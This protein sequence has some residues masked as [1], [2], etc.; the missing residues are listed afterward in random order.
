MIRRRVPAAGYVV[1]FLCSHARLVVETDGGRHD[2]QKAANAD[3][4]AELGPVRCR[5]VRSCNDEGPGTMNGFGKARLT[6]ETL[7]ERLPPN[8]PPDGERTNER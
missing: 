8:P 1:D 6:I 7:I 3:G 5:V 2:Q 4:T